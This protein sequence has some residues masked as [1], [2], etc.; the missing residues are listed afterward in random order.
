MRPHPLVARLEG[1]GYDRETIEPA[2]QALLAQRG[3]KAIDVRD[4]EASVNAI[5]DFILGGIGEPDADD[6]SRGD[7][8]EAEDGSGGSGSDVD[9]SDADLSSGSGTGGEDDDEDWQDDGKGGRD[10]SGE[11]SDDD[12]VE[13]IQPARKLPPTGA[14]DN[15]KRQ[16]P[17]VVS[18]G[19][20]VVVCPLL[21]L[22]QDQVRALCSLPNGGVPATFLSSQQTQDEV[23][24]VL[25]E[26]RKERPSCKL[27]YLTPEALVKGNRI[28]DLLDRLF[29]RGRLARFV[30]DET[31][32]PR[33]PVMALTATATERVK[34]D[35]LKKLAIDRTAITFKTSFHRPNLDFIVYDKPAG[36]T[37]DG[38][39]AD[40][41]ML[42]AHIQTKGAGTSG[43]VYCLSRDDCEDVARYLNANDIRAAHYHAGMTP[44]QR[45][46]VQ[47]KWRD[48][49]VAVVVATIAFGMGIDKANVRYVIHFSLSK[50]LEGYF[51]EAG[52][53]GRD[54][55]PSECVIYSAPKKDG[56]RI[57]FLIHQGRGNRD[58][59]MKNLQASWIGVACVGPAPVP[60]EMVEFCNARRTCRHQLL[61][62]YF[63][64]HSL[65]NG[66]GNRCDNCMNRTNRDWSEINENG[67]ETGPPRLPP[68]M[69]VLE[70]GEEEGGSWGGGGARKK[71]SGE[72]GGAKRVGGAAAGVQAGRKRSAPSDAGGTGFQT[73]A[74]LMKEQGAAG[75]RQATGKATGKA[76]VKAAAAAA[77]PA[78]T[79]FQTAASLRNAGAA[80]GGTAAGASAPDDFHAML[81]IMM[82]TAY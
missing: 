77:A 43:I 21:S 30:I 7:D 16:L 52:R 61:L 27:L 34:G 44:K 65:A 55:L 5:L 46:Q 51:Q 33:V 17:A 4:D 81:A 3:C 19:V 10:Q 64:D 56:N 13:I 74:S 37:K 23:M 47:N 45:T 38:K 63:A 58:T 41:E 20:T 15:K 35:I 75:K 14:G 36:R 29:Q 69:A 76:A 54:G 25:R 40:M 50:S 73:A 9:G 70:E 18:E 26:L 6:A 49:E 11:D 60:Q 31:R 22:M 71:A 53:A 66:C 79:G 59:A 68:W 2:F 24:S 39:P 12:F 32:Y 57:S 1:L 8:G 72:G 62:R 48:G 80:A 67:Q 42:V 28:K 82:L 78:F